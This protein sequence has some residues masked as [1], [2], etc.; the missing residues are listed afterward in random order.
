MRFGA[1]WMIRLEE[2]HMDF[3]SLIIQSAPKRLYPHGAA[4]E[5]FVG[6][7]GEISEG[8]L[9]SLS[10][11]GYKP[12]QIVG[13]QGLEK[14]YEQALR[15]REG[16]QYVEVDAHNRV[17]TNGRARE[18]VTPQE[19]PPLYTN[20]DLDLQEYINTLFGDTLAA[21]AVALVPQTGEVL[22]LYS[23]PALDPNRWVGGVSQ[24][25]MD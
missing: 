16:V 10:S 3:P 14:Q 21:A 25:Y 1:D 2:H 13:K 17:V 18:A 19:G 24:S 23:S 11:A 5:A 12:G 7:V 4:V 22:A 6:Y 20:I 15:G 9:G 8:E